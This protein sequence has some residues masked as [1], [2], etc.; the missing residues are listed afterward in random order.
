M[1]LTPDRGT[2]ERLTRYLLEEEEVTEEAIRLVLTYLETHA[3]GQG[4]I[5]D[6]SDCRYGWLLWNVK[7][8]A[9]ERS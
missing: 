7:D 5:M 3:D 4:R 2:A 9:P 1:P 8:K 6:D